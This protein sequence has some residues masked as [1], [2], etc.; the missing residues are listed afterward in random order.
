VCL[1]YQ[2]THS[3]RDEIA[4]IFIKRMRKLTERA[5]EE[6]ERMWRAERETT[7]PLIE[8]FTEVLQTSLESQNP[9]DTST[10]ICQVLESA[11]GAAR[12]L[13]ECE[14][15]NAHHGNRYQPFLKRFYASHR[16]ALFQVI[17]TLDLL[18]GCSATSP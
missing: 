18:P 10:Q 5:K 14:Q 15:V 16:R 9:A 12:L 8:V 17:K 7:E 2:A 3:T 1:L 4:Q 6:L 13:E 11:G